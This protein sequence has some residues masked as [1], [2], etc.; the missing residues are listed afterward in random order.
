MGDSNGVE[1]FGGKVGV[2]QTLIDDGHNCLDVRAG[3][4]FRNHAAIGRVDVDLR[5]DDIRQNV[6]AVFDDGSGSFVTGAF[7]AQNFHICY[8]TM[9]L[10]LCTGSELEPFMLLLT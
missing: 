6:T 1:I 5:N 4:N 7:D 9:I 10:R 3:G 2:L 8:Y